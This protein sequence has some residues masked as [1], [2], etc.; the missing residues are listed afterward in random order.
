MSIDTSELMSQ[1]DSLPIDLKMI[2]VEKILASIQPV[3]KRIDDLWI[4]EVERRTSSLESG[5][6][7][8]V[9]GHEVFLEIRKNYRK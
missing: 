7:K 2:I 5:E 4:Q 3:E 9:P 8:T 6:I 1:I